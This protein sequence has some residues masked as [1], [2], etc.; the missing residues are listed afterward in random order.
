MTTDG[1]VPLPEYLDLIRSSN[2]ELE[3]A[4]LR[5]EQPSPSTLAGR[6][7]LGTNT[8][9]SARMLG[10]QKFIKGFEAEPDGGVR[11]FNT[12]VVQGPLEERWTAKPSDA[13]PKRY[14]FFAVRPVEATARDNR[15]LNALLLDYGAGGNAWYDPAGRIRDYLVRVDE[16]LLLGKAYMAFGPARVKVGFFVLQRVDE[17]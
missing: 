4:L 13:D 2:D 7:F 3:K 5:G 6:E 8:P 15:Y 11:G 14:A 12:P 9:L 16:R 17:A 10:L 1:R